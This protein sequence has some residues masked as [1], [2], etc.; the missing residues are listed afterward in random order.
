[1]AAI[2]LVESAAR[3]ISEMIR[4]GQLV[5]GQRLPPE[6]ELAVTLNVSR[7]ALREALRT[8]EAV[9]VL[10]ARLGSGRFVSLS[11]SDGFSSGLSTWMHL[12]PVGDVI[13][14]RRILEPAAIR[15][16]PATRVT[17]TVA[18]C[19]R[20]LSKM[21]A[22]Y[23]RGAHQ[24]ATRYHT[25]FHLSLIQYAPSRLHRLLLASMIK[26]AETAQLEIFRTREAGR[27]SIAQHE[28]IFTA[29]EEGDVE[30]TARRVVDHLTP[31]FIYPFEEVDDS[32]PVD[33]PANEVEV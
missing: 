9:G 24:T 16:I 20:E 6:R 28:G 33:G 32:E 30:E 8:L 18:E 23:N 29:L 14:V 10:K 19:A 13:D 22:A 15:A 26:T 5:E 27:H 31:A 11:S 12:Q 17:A 25:Q 1:M 7:G 3:Q 4:S 21:K 2:S